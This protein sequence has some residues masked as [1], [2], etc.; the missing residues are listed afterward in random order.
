MGKGA[1]M[2]DDDAVDARLEAR[3]VFCRFDKAHNMTAALAAWQ[4]HPD[5]TI[6]TDGDLYIVK[7]GAKPLAE[8]WYATTAE[9][10]EEEIRRGCTDHVE[11]GP[12]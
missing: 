10:L 5:C 6:V 4:R 3:G 1:M 9:A 7:P 8:G 11:P 12:Q 2:F